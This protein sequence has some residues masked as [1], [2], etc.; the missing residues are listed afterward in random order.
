[1]KFTIHLLKL[2]VV[3]AALL[4]VTGCKT[5]P[6]GAKYLGHPLDIKFQAVD[7]RDVDL[8]KLRGS[9]VLVDFWATW[10]PPCVAEVPSVKAAYDKLHSRGF[11]VVGISADDDKDDL[12]SFISKKKLE[13]PQCLD[14]RSG[15]VSTQF[16]IDEIP[17]MWLIDKQGKVRDINGTEDLMAK[18]EKLLAETPSAK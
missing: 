8:N 4:Y 14:G 16:G 15:K 13:W 5:Q 11:E 17:A 18:V 2:T 3:L 6:Q 9:V 10:C 12:L 7:G 1:M